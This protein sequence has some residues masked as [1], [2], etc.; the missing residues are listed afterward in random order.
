MIKQLLIIVEFP[1]LYNILFE[2]QN[3]FAFSIINFH[4]SN[5]FLSTK[6]F[7]ENKKNSPIIIDKKKKY[8]LLDGGI[9]NENILVLESLPIKIEKLIDNINIQLIKQE[10][11]FQSQ[12][13]I[14]KYILNLNKR[15]II[16]DDKELKLTEREIDII[17]FLKNCTKP[18]SV[19][20]LQTKVWRYS[21]DLETH[22]VETHIYR[23]RKKIFDKFN[24]NH[25]ITST[26]DGYII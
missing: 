1:Q 16:T 20:S 15:I 21:F 25:F 22:T 26:K 14:K 7:D 4:N 11:S 17:L 3:S 19:N 13:I 5:D 18:Q 6:N 8:L 10:Y 24:D 2:L 12:I 9:K 23:L